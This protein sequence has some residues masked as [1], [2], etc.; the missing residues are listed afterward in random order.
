MTRFARSTSFLFAACV[1]I[2]TACIAPSRA[3]AQTVTLRGHGDIAHDSYIRALLASKDYLLITRDTVIARNDTVKP[4][5]LVVGATLRLDGTVM[6]DLVSIGGNVFVRPSA[7]VIGETHN[8]AGGLYPSELA[9]MNPVIE[10]SPNAPYQIVTTP[11]SIDIVG[12][13]HPSVLELSGIK[14]LSIPTYDRVNGVTL[15]LGAGFILPTAG[16]TESILRAWGTYYSQRGDF[17]GGAELGV[18]RGWTAVTAGAERTFLT[19][20]RWIRR[21]ISNSL[22]TLLQGNDYRTYY[23]ADRAYVSLARTLE[24]SARVT[25]AGL[26]AQ[27]EEAS[28]LRA[29]RPWSLHAAD[30][31]RPNDY[32]A[33]ADGTRR[34]PDG[35]ITSGI[36]TLGTKWD[37]PTFIATVSG[38]TEVG[39]TALGG[40]SSFARYALSG[41]VA[42]A[43]LRH[44]TLEVEWHFQGPLP[45]TDSLPYQ[46][47]TFV[48]GSGTLQTFQ[49]E[50]FTGDRVAFVAT[51]YTFPLPASLTLPLVGRPG[52]DLLHYAAMAWS[53]DQKRGLE[54]NVGFRL[55]YRILYLRVLANPRDLG[56]HRSTTIGI[57][58]PRGSFPWETPGPPPKK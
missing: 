32:G 57:T 30:S 58:F 24:K 55:G 36:A 19:N 11:A 51:K 22:S 39:T 15:R 38:L 8:I 1:A 20:E 43:A 53:K 42:M 26:T 44:N 9:H 40:A 50:A 6:R 54:Q 13:L 17:G 12:S 46:R 7:N 49:T 47:W 25:T 10:N 34:L 33:R 5:V 16:R 41:D 52:I 35:R 29:G 37:R 31:I 27:V 21:D 48:G 4:T 2:V 28:P 23:G 18:T 45:G 56:N 3:S 14:G